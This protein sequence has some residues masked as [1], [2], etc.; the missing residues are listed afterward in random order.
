MNGRQF[1]YFMQGLT[2]AYPGNA[3]CWRT[4]SCR[5]IRTPRSACSASTARASRRCCKIMAG[6]RQGIYRRSLGRRGRARRLSAA[7]AATRSR[8]KRSRERHGRRR[9]EEGDPR[10]LQRTRDELFRRDRRRDDEAAGRDR[11]AG[12]VGS[13]FQGR[14][15]DGCAALPARRRRRRRSSPAANAAASRCAGCCSSSPTCCCSTSRPTISTPKAWP[16]SKGICA[17]IP[18]RS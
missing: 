12:P 7:G 2:K 11:G 8:Q 6:H 5:S 1:I 13:R 16:G 3:R 14:H 4:S 18:A 9:R 17:T 15:G 10:P